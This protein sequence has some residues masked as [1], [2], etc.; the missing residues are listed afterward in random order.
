MTKTINIVHKIK[1]YTIHTLVRKSN[2]KGEKRGKKRIQ[3]Y[4]TKKKIEVST[5]LNNWLVPIQFVNALKL[6][7]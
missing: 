6:T 7:S 3:I 4:F 1:E 5:V 2:L